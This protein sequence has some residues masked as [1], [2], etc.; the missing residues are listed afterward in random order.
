MAERL[1]RVDVGQVDLDDGFG[2]AARRVEQGDAGVGEGAAVEDAGVGAVA[3][4]L[5]DV[6]QGALVVVLLKAD[7]DG[8]ARGS[9]TEHLLDV[10]QRGGSVDLGLTAT[11]SAQ[12]GAIED[13]NS[14]HACCTR[15]I[16]PATAASGTTWP[17]LAL[18]RRATGHPPPP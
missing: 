17:E 13:Q 18:P 15:A 8:I 1:A 9:I 12:V 14:T 16:A 3:L 4:L 6:D 2:E 7:V 5:E 10:G 11:Q